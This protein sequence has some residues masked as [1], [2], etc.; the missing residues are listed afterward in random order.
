MTQAETR[1]LSCTQCGDQCGIA[2][3][4]VS[5]S[6]WGPAVINQDGTVRPQDPDGGFGHKHDPRPIRVRAY[7][8]SCGHQWTLRR[9]VDT[10]A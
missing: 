5:Y 9:R 7:C 2:E 10:T 1:P 4:Y 3:D 8:P 6:D